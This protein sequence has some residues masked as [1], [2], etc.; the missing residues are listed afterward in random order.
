[1]YPSAAGPATR[2]ATTS[3]ARSAITP[4]LDSVSVH[5]TR[6]VALN[7]AIAK[8]GRITIGITLYEAAS[9]AA[10]NATTRHAD[11]RDDRS[12]CVHAP[13]D[14]SPE[15]LAQRLRQ[16]RVKSDRKLQR[17]KRAWPVDDQVIEAVNKGL[18]L[19]AF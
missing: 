9:P 6:P 12:A 5:R 10:P 15:L 8:S 18:G 7:T 16:R 13:S 3:G 1:M 19:I 14:P 11:G 2:A 17:V 4:A